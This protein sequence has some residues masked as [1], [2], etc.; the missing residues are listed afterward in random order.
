MYSVAVSASDSSARRLFVY[1]GVYVLLL[2][3]VLLVEQSLLWTL[4]QVNEVFYV[5]RKQAKCGHCEVHCEIRLKKQ[6]C[7]SNPNPGGLF[8]DEMLRGV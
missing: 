8:D 3:H 2:I 7:E 4:R 5:Q 1:D 6:R